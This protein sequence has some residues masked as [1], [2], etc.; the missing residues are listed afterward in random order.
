LVPQHADFSD[1]AQ[2]VCWSVAEQQAVGCGACASAGVGT[3]SAG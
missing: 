1:G 3:D 2:Q